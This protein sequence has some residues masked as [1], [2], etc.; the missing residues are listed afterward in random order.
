M[1]LWTS[2]W[3]IGQ[4]NGLIGQLGPITFAFQWNL[5]PLAN[6]K[7]SIRRIVE[8][9]WG[10][11]PL[12]RKCDGAE[13]TN[14]AIPL[15]DA[16]ATGPKTQV[17][18]P[19]PNR[20]MSTPMEPAVFIIIGNRKSKSVRQSIYLVPTVPDL[21]LQLEISTKDGLPSVFASSK[22]R[23]MHLLKKPLRSSSL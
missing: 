12:E 1:S 20:M 2:C 6:D 7:K 22:N 17:A 4:W 19:K 18:R 11:I 5:A 9:Q 16:P 23:Y 3:C 15:T 13:L 8:G 21:K 14:Q 10:Q